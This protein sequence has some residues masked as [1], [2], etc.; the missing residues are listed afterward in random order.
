MAGIETI[1]VSTVLQMESTRETLSISKV[2]ELTNNLI[3]ERKGKDLT[4]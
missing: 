4:L 3:K 1:L 2:L